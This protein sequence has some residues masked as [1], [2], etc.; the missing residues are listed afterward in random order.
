MDTIKK[1]YGPYNYCT[2]E[3]PSISLRIKAIYAADETLFAWN[4]KAGRAPVSKPE[5]IG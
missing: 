4:D 5:K 2:I 3:D 1:G